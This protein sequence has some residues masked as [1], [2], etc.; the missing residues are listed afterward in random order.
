[1]RCET[2]IRNFGTDA[3]V[4]EAVRQPPA[5]AADATALPKVT[6][7]MSVSPYASVSGKIV[8]PRAVF[9]VTLVYSDKGT[10]KMWLSRRL[11]HTSMLQA[12]TAQAHTALR[13]DIRHG[14]RSR[15]LAPITAVLSTKGREECP[16]GGPEGSAD[17]RDRPCEPLGTLSCGL[18]RSG[19]KLGSARLES[20]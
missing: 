5:P 16:E 8:T 9:T 4:T 3:K 1:M 2:L 15:P 20:F 11:R 13:S 7:S 12:R 17:D 6:A 10:G 18:G 14:P 19:P